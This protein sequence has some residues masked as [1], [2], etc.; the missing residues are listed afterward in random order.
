MNTPEKIAGAY[1]RLNGFFLLPHFTLF[2]GTRHTHL[3]FLA[4]RPPNGNERCGGIELPLDDPLFE[5]LN[6]VLRCNPQTVLLGGIVQMK[7]GEQGKAPAERHIAYAR[8]F[9]G[10]Q[11]KLVSLSFSDRDREILSKNKTIFI[12]IQYSLEWIMKRIDWM[13]RNVP[14]LTK[15]GSW[16]WS[17]DFLSDILYLC[18]HLSSRRDVGRNDGR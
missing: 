3:D 1:L 13:N 6:K 10:P 14:G 16:A 15:T 11:A 7:G 18:S 5:A 4:L 9:M 12:P 2:D 17:E 8:D